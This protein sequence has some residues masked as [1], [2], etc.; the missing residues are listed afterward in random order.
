MTRVL[1]LW[2]CRPVQ[3]DTAPVG[4]WTREA[5]SETSPLNRR[6]SAVLPPLRFHSKQV[7]QRPFLSV[8]QRLLLGSAGSLLLDFRNS[9]T[10]A[11]SGH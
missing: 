6:G 7:S 3:R 4:S 2:V 5:I 8:K 11:E 10:P 1:H 9:R